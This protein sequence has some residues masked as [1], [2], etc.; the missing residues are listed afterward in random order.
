MSQISKEAIAGVWPT[1]LGEAR[2]TRAFPSIAASG[3]GR[4]LGRLY[5]LPFPWGFLIHIATL[6]VPI[7]LAVL[8]FLCSEFRRYVL[9]NQRVCIC[10]GFADRPGP[11]VML[12]ELEDVRTVVRPGQ[13][14]YRTADLELIS[15]GRAALILPGV[16]LAE[17]FR[18]NILEARDALVQVRKCRESQQ[19]AAAAAAS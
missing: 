2:I 5:A 19:P 14:F 7:S 6:P 3:A 12:A 8:M 16:Y 17:G 4:L 11:Q 1:E 10:R 15:G 9:T 18:H 13:Q